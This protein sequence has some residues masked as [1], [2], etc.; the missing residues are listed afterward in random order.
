M[1]LSFISHE[2]Q[3]LLSKI[4]KE[5]FADLALEGIFPSQDNVNDAVLLDAGSL[6]EAEYLQRAI[7]RA[8]R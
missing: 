7:E 5:A 4:T 8:K 2:T 1:L 3:L 6:T